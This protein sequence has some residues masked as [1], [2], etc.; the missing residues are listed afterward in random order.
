MKSI[1]T[2]G[3][4]SSIIMLRHIFTLLV[5]I[6]VS[7]ETFAQARTVKPG[8]WSGDSAQ[9]TVTKTAVAF[10]FGCS[11]GSTAL[12]LRIDKHGAFRLKGT[13]T[14]GTGANPPAGMQPQPQSVFFVGTI[15]GSKMTLSIDFPNSERPSPTYELVAGPPVK[16]IPR[17][18]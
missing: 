11:A 10:D 13:Y 17:C 15:N 6:L 4:R 14:S 16:D 9:V 1:L 12:P 8:Q 2:R 3:R 18:S 5:L 7:M